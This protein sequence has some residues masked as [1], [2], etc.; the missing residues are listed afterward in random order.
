MAMFI[1]VAV[2][3]GPEL[4]KLAMQIYRTAAGDDLTP[5]AKRAEYARIADALEI[6]N[7]IVLASPLP[8]PGSG[9]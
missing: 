5:T 9:R 1:P 4:I 8:P 7:D 6:A 2:A 3:L